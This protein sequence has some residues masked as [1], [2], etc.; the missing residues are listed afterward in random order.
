MG[1]SPGLRHHLF[2]SQI[3]C[4]CRSNSLFRAIKVPVRSNNRACCARHKKLLISAVSAGQMPLGVS[5]HALFWGQFT[6]NS[7]FNR[8]TA[9]SASPSEN[10]PAD[11]AGKAPEFSEP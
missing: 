6:A 1:L 11:K 7:L 2:F 10:G 5:A 4:K 9:L 8:E 3:A